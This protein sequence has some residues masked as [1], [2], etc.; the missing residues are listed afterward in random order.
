MQRFEDTRKFL[1]FHRNLHREK[2]RKCNEK[3]NQKWKFIKVEKFYL[4]LQRNRK[5]KQIEN[6]FVK[7]TVSITLLTRC[8]CL[9]A[10]CCY[11]YNFIDILRSIFPID[12]QQKL[13]EFSICTSAEEKLVLKDGKDE[14]FS[15][16]RRFLFQLP[17][18][19]LFL[20]S[21]LREWRRI[22]ESVFICCNNFL[23][24]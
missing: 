11:K 15:Q 5:L 1:V 20:A 8:K 19:G 13:I 23:C 2:K 17:R 4:K 14:K 24:L 21:R 16:A 12:W 3:V 7:E 9:K 18:T 6:E 10:V 22:H